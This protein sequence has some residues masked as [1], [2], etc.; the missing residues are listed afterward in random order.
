M[1]ITV[2]TNSFVTLVE[3]NSYFISRY[4][5]PDYWNDDLTQ[6][7]KEASLITAYNQ[8][9]N[10]GIFSF[11]E[12]TT[13]IVKDAQCEQALFLLIHGKDLDRRIGLQAQGVK[14]SNVVGETY[15]DKSGGEIVIAPIVEQMLK[16]IKNKHG[17]YGITLERDEEEDVL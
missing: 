15:K 1:A 3:A 17:F 11:P 13:Q 4:G 6:Q 8:L 14:S 9:N 10:C 16:D 5:A 2:D 12:E 7:D